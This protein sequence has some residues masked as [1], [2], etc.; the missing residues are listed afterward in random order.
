MKNKILIFKLLI[1]VF[2]INIDFFAQ[3][4]TQNE[5]KIPSV[6]KAPICYRV[7]D[8]KN[9]L[10]GYYKKEYS[11]TIYG[12]S[13][14]IAFRADC[15]EDEDWSGAITEGTTQ[16]TN[17]FESTFHCTFNPNILF[18][19]V[20]PGNKT[21]QNHWDKMKN[22]GIGIGDLTITY[23]LDKNNKLIDSV[24]G[25]VFDRGPQCQPGESSVAVCK[26]FKNHL[27]NNQFI[28]IVFPNSAK[29]LQQ[30]IGMKKD[31]ISLSR[32]PTNIDFEKAFLLMSEEKAN[33][34]RMQSNYKLY[35]ALS[36]IGVIFNFDNA[37]EQEKSNGML[38]PKNNDRNINE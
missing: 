15:D 6:S 3:T 12:D 28:Y 18:G 17:S 13:N 7:N 5:A 27:D 24:I 9:A 37:S 4:L 32:T 25:V 8:N 29:Y 14:A 21:G 1:I 31:N 35:H 36:S 26:K 20:L 19:T 38:K 34:L 22:L 33:G 16:A 2:T 23:Q 11:L 30:T 10:H